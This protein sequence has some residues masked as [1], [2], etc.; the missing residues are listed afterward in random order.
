LKKKKLF[1]WVCDYSKNTGEGKL[2]RLFIKYLSSRGYI[3]SF[4]QKKR[5]K[6]KYLSTLNGILYCWKKYFNDHKVCYINYLPFWNFIIFAFLPPNTILGP[7]T[8][9][10]N[11]INTNNY[12]Q[13]IR[14]FF[15]PFCYKISELLINTRFKK[16]FF[17]TSLLK[18]YLKK[19]TIIRCKFDFS[20]KYFIKTNK[21]RKKIDFIIYH[22]NHQNKYDKSF[23]KLLSI[24]IHKKL[25]IIVVG[26]KLNLKYVKNLGRISNRKL[27]Q[28]Q[29]LSKFTVASNENIYSLFIIECLSN[30]V[31]VLISNSYKNQV[32]FKKKDFI[33]YDNK[34]LSLLNKIIN[35]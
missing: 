8:G 28:Y 31:K 26:D 34:N 12:N 3:I 15:F 35:C 24:L 17:S 7:I 10:S 1:V 23:Y 30:H 32:K 16:I 6:S 13:L 4:N 19:K 18:K 21:K 27:A 11:I 5:L 2:A 9:G 22:R 20:L 25:K 14:N 29:S 33:F